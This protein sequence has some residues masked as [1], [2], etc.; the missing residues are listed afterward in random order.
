MLNLYPLSLNSFF[1]ILFTSLNQYEPSLIIY[2]FPLVF[3]GYSIAKTCAIATSLTSTKLKLNY[4]KGK[5]FQNIENNSK[6]GEGLFIIK[7]PKNIPG[8]ITVKFI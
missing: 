7:G 6:L 8:H 3:S 5:F 1:K 4:A 2:L